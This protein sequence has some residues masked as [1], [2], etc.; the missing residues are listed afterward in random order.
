[1]V[2]SPIDSIQFRLS[3]PDA[4]SDPGANAFMTR[5]VAGN[6]KNFGSPLAQSLHYTASTGPQH[7]VQSEEKRK[8]SMVK[9]KIGKEGNGQ[10][11]QNGIVLDPVK[12]VKDQEA[13]L[14]LLLESDYQLLWESKENFEDQA[15]N[16]NIYFEVIDPAENATVLDGQK[17]NAGEHNESLA[18]VHFSSGQQQNSPSPRV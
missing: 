1:M 5:N 16:L 14:E 3:S 11:A 13:D 17:S 6:R 15:K 4:L 10:E 12:L 8:K 7:P 2:R 9:N 18:G